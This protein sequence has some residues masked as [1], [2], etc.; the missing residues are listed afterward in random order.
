MLGVRVPPALISHRRARRIE[1]NGE[2]TLQGVQ[3]YVV[4]AFLAIGLLLWATLARLLTALAYLAN[5]PDLPLL[6]NNFTL[7]NLLSLLV[8]AGAAIFAYRNKRAYNFSTDV[9]QELRKVTWP[10][11]KETRTATVV[12]IVCTIIVA[13][14]LGFFD[15]VWAK[16]TGLIYNK[17]V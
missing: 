1:T 17:P 6:G 13:I 5:V 11:R 10:S 3:R 16:L 14:I 7:A 15:M 12:V 4:F 8:A 2:A 9:I